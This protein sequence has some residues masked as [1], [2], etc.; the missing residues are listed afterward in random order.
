MILLRVLVFLIQKKK[1][2]VVRTSFI[3]SWKNVS[4]HVLY[5]FPLVNQSVFCYRGTISRLGPLIDT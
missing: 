3:S 2:L 5:V 1:K 4:K